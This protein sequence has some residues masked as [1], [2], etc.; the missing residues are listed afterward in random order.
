MQSVMQHILSADYTIPQEAARTTSPELIDLLSRL[1]VADPKK[2]ATLPE[3]TAHPWFIQGLPPLALE[4][5]DH[6]VRRKRYAGY[7]SEE[8]IMTIISGAS[9]PAQGTA[10]MGHQHQGPRASWATAMWNFLTSHLPAIR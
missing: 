7:Q 9:R 2:R 6:L 4:N 5:N 8:D 3:I 10:V 1:L